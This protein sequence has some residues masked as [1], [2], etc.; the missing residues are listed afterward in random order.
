MEKTFEDSTTISIVFLTKAP[1][2]KILFRALKILSNRK[3]I[4]VKAVI[5]EDI[6]HLPLIKFIFRTLR[7]II[8]G[9]LR[10]HDLARWGMMGIKQKIFNKSKD[11]INKDPLKNLLKER[12]IPL[13]FVKNTENKETIDLI[14]N[15]QPDLNVIFMHRI[16]KKELFSIPKIFTINLHSGLLPRYPG[17]DP[18]F[19]SLV[20]GKKE[21]GLTVHEV[22]ERVDSGRIILVKKIPIVSQSIRDLNEKVMDMV[23]EA[24]LEAILKIKSNKNTPFIVHNNGERLYRHPPSIYTK[25]KFYAK[26]KYKG[27]IKHL[28]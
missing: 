21:V 13:F 1:T 23:P 15:L 12:N 19:W 11:F 8:K 4:E 26:L 10:A 14:K 2:G 20:D 27:F 6:I 17:G 9:G 16:L 25:L 22:I 3:E 18:C 7:R 28:K 24:L 5:V